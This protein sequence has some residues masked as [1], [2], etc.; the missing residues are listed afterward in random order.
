MKRRIVTREIGTMPF[1][2]LPRFN[3]SS[4][5]SQTENDDRSTCPSLPRIRIAVMPLWNFAVNVMQ[6]MPTMICEWSASIKCDMTHAYMRFLVCRHG[7][8][9]DGA[10][11]S[12][13]VS[14][15]VHL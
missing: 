11:I 15:S 6:R 2:R 14:L 5:S 13:Q 7:R 8:H 3:P 1:E 12:I 4:P 9:F 10:R